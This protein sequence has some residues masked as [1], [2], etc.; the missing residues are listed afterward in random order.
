MVPFQKAGPQMRYPECR[1][2]YSIT[3]PGGQRRLRGGSSLSYGWEAVNFL[4][5]E[6]VRLLRPF[7]VRVCVKLAKNDK[8]GA[9]MRTSN[10]GLRPLMLGKDGQP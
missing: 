5:R 10:L 2:R 4:R 9:M 7:G 1:P 3:E 8:G 6:R